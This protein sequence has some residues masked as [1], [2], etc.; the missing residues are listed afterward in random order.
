MPTVP[1]S[2]EQRLD[3]AGQL[4]AKDIAGKG[5]IELDT[6]GLVLKHGPNG[7]SAKGRLAKTWDMVAD[8]NA[9]DLSRSLPDVKGSLQGKIL[10]RGKMTE[11]ELDVD[12]VGNRSEE[13][14]VG[15]E[16]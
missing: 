2:L 12:L 16:C 7:F 3:L 15:K 4:S 6:E 13:R 1:E 8:I 14:R 10:L 11:P 5:E 9:P